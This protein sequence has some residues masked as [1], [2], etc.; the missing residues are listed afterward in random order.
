[1]TTRLFLASLHLIALGIG[2]GAVFARAR[3]LREPLDD[4]RLPRVFFIDNLW[5]LAAALW[6]VTGLA[7][8][9][10][11][12]EKGSAYYLATPLFHL[13]MALF[14][15]VFLLEMWPMITLVRWR[16]RRRRGEP[17]DTSAAETIARISYV[18]TA[19]VVV[20]VFV[21]SAMARGV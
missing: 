5:A 21:A 2:L 18:Q 17:V 7:R 13:K 19:I 12:Y 16:G 6:L 20:M 11:G 4:A 3:A 9:I 8:V 10:G 15:V 1:M 14:L